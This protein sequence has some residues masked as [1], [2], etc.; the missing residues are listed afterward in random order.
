[1]FI[2]LD[3]SISYSWKLPSLSQ[4][5]AKLIDE[6]KQAEPELAEKMF[7]SYAYSYHHKISQSYLKAAY[8][9]WVTAGSP[10]GKFKE[11][12]R[13]CEKSTSGI[14]LKA[15]L[16]APFNLELGPLSEYRHKDP[17]HKFDPNYEADGSMSPRSRAM[18]KELKSTYPLFNEIGAAII[19]AHEIHVNELKLD[20]TMVSSPV[21][22][23]WSL[24]EDT[25]KWQ[26]TCA[27]KLRNAV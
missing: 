15:L 4:Q 12:V 10:E 19:K 2:S 24:Q 6:A 18:Q 8:K 13:I 1:M 7:D 9:D 23:Q 14:G 26:R 21:L 16:N 5:A 27:F 3:L 22:A 25:K 20:R 11:A 17:G